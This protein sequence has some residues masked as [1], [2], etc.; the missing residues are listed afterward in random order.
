MAIKQLYNDKLRKLPNEYGDVSV[1]TYKKYFKHKRI[2]F[3][4]TVF[5][6]KHVRP[7]IYVF[8]GSQPYLGFCPDPKH[9]IVNFVENTVKNAEKSGKIKWKMKY[10]Y[11]IFL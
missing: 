3:K 10:L 6:L 2:Q 7:K 4:Y 8:Q 1:M 5:C 11:K 9:F